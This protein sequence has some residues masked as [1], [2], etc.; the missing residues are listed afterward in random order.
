MAAGNFEP[1]AGREKFK[2]VQLSHAELKCDL[3]IRHGRGGQDIPCFSPLP[4]T[5]PVMEHNQ[6]VYAGQ[7]SPTGIFLW[8]SWPCTALKPSR[9]VGWPNTHCPSSRVH[10]PLLKNMHFTACE[11]VDTRAHREG[12][13]LATLYHTPRLHIIMEDA[14]RFSALLSFSGAA[15]VILNNQ[16]Q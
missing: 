13:G 10:V 8:R 2:P 1:T 15:E 11:F 9:Y 7:K 12:C 6:M 16:T 3:P 14:V 4:C 5:A